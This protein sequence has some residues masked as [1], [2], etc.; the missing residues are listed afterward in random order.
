M[1]ALAFSREPGGQ[2]AQLLSVGHG[3]NH[4][5]AIWR[6]T[7]GHWSRAALVASGRGDAGRVLFAHW[8]PPGGGFSCVTGGLRHLSF[9]AAEGPDLRAKRGLFGRLEKEHSTTLTGT[10]PAA[11]GTPLRVC[12]HAGWALPNSVGRRV[13]LG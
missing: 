7:G 1:A 5:H 8:L 13:R 12:P 4:L 11:R 9:W 2:S 6:D 10:T 3:D